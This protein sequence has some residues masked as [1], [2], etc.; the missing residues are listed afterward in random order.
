MK[1]N[2]RG[3]LNGPTRVYSS[4]E[5]KINR[6][7]LINHKKITSP[8]SI[9]NKNNTSTFKSESSDTNEELYKIGL[10]VDALD[11]NQK[12][13]EQRFGKEFMQLQ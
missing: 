8:R 10:R 6:N 13:L 11:E 1:E 2:G 12:R 5:I 3:S 9:N 7:F 4:K